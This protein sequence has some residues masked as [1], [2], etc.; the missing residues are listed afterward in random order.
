MTIEKTS[1]TSH[2][3]HKAGS[4]SDSSAGAK[5]VKDGAAAGGFMAILDSLGD[6]AQAASGTSASMITSAPP[7]TARTAALPD[8]ASV[9]PVADPTTQPTLNPQTVAAQVLAGQTKAARELNVCCLA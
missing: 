1:A 8:P 4:A 3:H 5:G 6:E 2:H 7:D 9:A